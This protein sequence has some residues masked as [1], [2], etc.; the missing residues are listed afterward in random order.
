LGGLELRIFGY[1][2]GHVDWGEVDVFGGFRH[3][4]FEFF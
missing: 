1:E 2:F 4:E 3:L